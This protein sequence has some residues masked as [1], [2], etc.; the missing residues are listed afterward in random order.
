VTVGIQQNV[1]RL[2]I[3]MDVAESVDR[4]DKKNDLL[5]LSV[6]IISGGANQVALFTKIENKR[7]DYVD[8]V[9]TC[10]AV[11]HKE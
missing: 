4:V 9:L 7:V 11:L 3:S 2:D 6:E 1:I 8:S 5:V 10:T